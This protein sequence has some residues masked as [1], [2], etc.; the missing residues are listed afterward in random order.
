MTE[1]SAIEP[2][3][4]WTINYRRILNFVFGICMA[5]GSLVFIEPSPY[6][7]L[8]LLPIILWIIGGFS[9][10]RAVL[11]F[12]FLLAMWVLSGYIALIPYCVQPDP[13]NLLTYTAFIPSTR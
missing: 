4:G 9:I 2:P 6:D 5:S 13:P 11:P 1:A 8:I 7:Y 10:H 12:L 3:A